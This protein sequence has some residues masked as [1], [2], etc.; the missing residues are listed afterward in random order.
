MAIPRPRVR[1]NHPRQLPNRS[2]ADCGYSNKTSATL[3]ARP[4]PIFASGV[5]S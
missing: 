2:S 5:C 3:H 1:P 4:T